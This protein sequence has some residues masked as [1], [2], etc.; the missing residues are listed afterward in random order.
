MGF[1]VSRGEE[2]VLQMMPQAR[3]GHFIAEARPPTR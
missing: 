3:L 2:G 1:K